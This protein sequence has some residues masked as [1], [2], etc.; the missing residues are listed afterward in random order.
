MAAHA[1]P[2]YR[3]APP[4]PAAPEGELLGVPM[5]RSAY[6]MPT[7]S[8]RRHRAPHRHSG[9]FAVVGGVTGMTVTAITVKTGAVAAISS[10]VVAAQA[11]FR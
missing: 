8:H 1:A 9:A 4:P 3:T 2:L 5:G 6:R 10:V 7:S 11:L